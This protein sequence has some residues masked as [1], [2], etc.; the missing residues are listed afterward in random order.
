MILEVDIRMT[1]VRVGV[2]VLLHI[3]W[4]TDSIIDD[5]SSSVAASIMAPHSVATHVAEERV[6]AIDI[7]ITRTKLCWTACSRPR[8]MLAGRA[9]FKD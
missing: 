9:L 1:V 4:P 7:T 6:P 8:Q 2:L 5:F 3:Y